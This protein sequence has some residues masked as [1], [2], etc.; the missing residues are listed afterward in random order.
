[1]PVKRAYCF[2]VCG[3]KADAVREVKQLLVCTAVFEVPV[4]THR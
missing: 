1:M 2:V 4:Y 3:D